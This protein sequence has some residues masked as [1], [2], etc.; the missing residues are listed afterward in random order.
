MNSDWEYYYI[1]YGATSDEIKAESDTLISYYGSGE[2]E[3]FA[4]VGSSEYNCYSDTQDN[5]YDDNES[6]WFVL[7][8]DDDCTD[9]TQTKSPVIDDI[10]SI[11][12][13][14]EHEETGA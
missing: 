3:F 6:A 13:S 4:G 8:I 7:Q 9:Y 11:G 12:Y 10:T 14:D 2:I 5:Y 1:H